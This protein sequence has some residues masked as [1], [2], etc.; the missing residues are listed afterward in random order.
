MKQQLDN[1]YLRLSQIIGNPQSN[2]PILP[3]IPIGKTSWWAGVKS[4]KYPKPIK[5]GA[6]TTVWKSEDILALIT[7][8]PAKIGGAHE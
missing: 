5:L 3:L 6:R 2:P 8:G 1:F 7:H 4:G